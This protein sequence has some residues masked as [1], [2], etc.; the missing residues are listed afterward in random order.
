MNLYS[1]IN[2]IGYIGSYYAIGAAWQLTLINYFVVGWFDD[3]VDMYY[4]PSFEVLFTSVLVFTVLSNVAFAV[5][6]YRR[7][8]MGLLKAVW[9]NVRWVPFFA[10]FFS[11]LSF[12]V[13]V[14][15]ASHWVGYNMT[16]GATA[17]ELEASN[18]FKEGKCNCVCVCFFFVNFFL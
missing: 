17:K 1:K 9:E 15:L 14:A 4:L 12:H 11:G 16:W 10:V 3:T 7:G 2:I 13:W 5:F 8:E 18:F 6:R